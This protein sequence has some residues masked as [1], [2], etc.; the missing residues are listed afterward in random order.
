MA[1]CAVGAVKRA[2]TATVRAAAEAAARAAEGAAPLH[3]ASEAAVVPGHSDATAVQQAMAAA[4]QVLLATGAEAAAQVEAA[5]AALGLEQARGAGKVLAG[6][7][8]GQT[9]EVADCR[10]WLGIVMCKQYSRR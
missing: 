6:A 9:A 7:S 5:I 1:A 2:R 4:E 8:Y 10:G 3:A